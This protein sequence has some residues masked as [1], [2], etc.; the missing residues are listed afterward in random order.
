MFLKNLVACAML[1]VASAAACAAGLALDVSGKIT[2]FTDRDAGVYHFGE[3]QLLSM[4]VHSIRTGTSWTRVSTFSGP[5]LSDVLDQVGAQGTELEFH[6][7]DDYIKMIPV[8]DA[9]RYGVVLA[10][11]MNGDRLPINTFGPLFLVYPRDRYLN[12]LG[13][14]SSEAKFVWQIKSIIVK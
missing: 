7:L 12:E 5:L 13:T 14:P 9:A 8:S 2:R 6:A 10:Y 11:R 4:P 3:A 1:C